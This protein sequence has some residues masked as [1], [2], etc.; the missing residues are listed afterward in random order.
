[1]KTTNLKSYLTVAISATALTL[2]VGAYSSKPAFALT[3][4]ASSTTSSQSTTD[5][6]AV[7][8]P[9]QPTG[10]GA[11]T[12]T[13][14]STTGLWVNQY[15]SW[16]P[17]TGQTTP[18]TPQ[19]YTYDPATG[20][21]NT[22]EWVY[23]AA[24]QSYVPNVETVSQP[25]AGAVLN[26]APD[27]ADSTGPN[28]DTTTSSDTNNNA[29]LN[30]SNTSTV[31]NN[32]NSSAKSG[33][34][35]V[36][37]NT[38][39]G[40]GST[41]DA[42]S[43]VDDLNELSSSSDLGDDGAQTFV[44]NIYG[45]VDTNL[46]LDPT[47]SVI[48]GPDSSYDPNTVTSDNLDINNQNSGEIN[49][50]I[51]TAAASGDADVD[52][53]TSAGDATSGD[54]DAIANVVNMIDSMITSGQSFVGTINVYG[55]LNGNILLPASFLNDLIASNAPSET[56]NSSDL[57]NQTLNDNT[58]NNGDITNNL[59]SN[60]TTG[61]ADVS[62]NTSAGNATTGDASSNVTVFNLTGDNVVAS[63]ALLVFVNV[64]GTWVGLLLNAPAGATAAAYG[65]GVTDATTTT[66]NT[67]N[68]NTT[69]NDV[70]NNNITADATSGNAS[71][72]DNTTAGNATTGEADTSINL[73]N[74]LGSNF[75][76]SG[77]FGILFINI[78]GNWTGSLGVNTPVTITTT[79]S[80][81][82]TTSTTVQQFKAIAPNIVIPASFASTL[83][84][85]VSNSSFN[86]A[87]LASNLAKNVSAPVIS[88]TITSNKTPEA[89]ALNA[90]T[91]KVR[92]NTTI[93]IITLVAAGLLFSLERYLTI[94]ARNK[95]RIV[96]K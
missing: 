55:N 46:A 16:N 24:S 41:G 51:T 5:D 11:N 43:T 85:A 28:S 81:G 53:N 76:I 78:F 48:S 35:T 52:G 68:I 29:N 42:N 82:S 95:A 87:T 6:S 39:A 31:N 17:V 72:T 61:S 9:K 3:S 91:T 65:S 62:D 50:N 40:D 66:N 23:D 77:W 27:A 49:N 59:T 64:E 54:A 38:S 18:L 90:N 37:Q 14:D 60:A 69:N 88:S 89:S 25:P 56:I 7:S 12:Y 86:S 44:Y 73:L 2:V 57:T 32:V 94:T 79:T 92:V 19:S 63:N 33:D 13:Y 22:T 74:I 71:V 8:G 83:D 58:T 10:A 70:I 1:M 47:Q 34:A 4:A 30:N 36:S 67:A 93:I 15:Y 96:K 45:N 80:G 21:W 75:N 20:M 26:N 84:N